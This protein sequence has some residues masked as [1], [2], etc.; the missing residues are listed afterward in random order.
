MRVYYTGSGCYEALTNCIG[1]F[2]TNSPADLRT[3]SCP[4]RVCLDSDTLFADGEITEDLDWS[5]LPLTI[6]IATYITYPSALALDLIRIGK[7]THTSY[8]ALNS[9]YDGLFSL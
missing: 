4:S 7:G 6:D 2:D 1:C 8:V 3:I 5:D 9:T